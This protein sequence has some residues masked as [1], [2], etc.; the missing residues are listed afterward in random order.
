LVLKR[1]FHLDAGE[2]GLLLSG[3]GTGSL[4]SILAGGWLTDR[5][6]RRRTL[7]VSLTR[8]GLL[9]VAMSRA[10]SLPVFLGFL[11]PFGF[12]ADLYRPASS[13]IL[14]DLLPSSERATGY[15]AVRVAVN[16]GF[17][18]G[19]AAG[20]LLADWSWRLLFV[21]DGLTTLAFCLVVAL[22]VTETAPH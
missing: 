16:L 7:L 4:A 2:V 10:P 21:L 18:F 11:L 15:A 19:V 8:G 9:A 6:G 12:P 14:A 5:V 17:A 1:D 22:F 20:G 3:Y 13:A